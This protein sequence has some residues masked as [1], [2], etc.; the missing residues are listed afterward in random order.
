MWNE[1]MFYRRGVKLWGDGKDVGFKPTQIQWVFRQV[2]NCPNVFNI[3]NEEFQM[4]LDT[5]EN[6]VWMWGD[7]QDEGQHPD[8]IRWE[9]KAI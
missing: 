6:A 4:F 9:W 8:N 3:V 2:P 7:G 5:H 1:S